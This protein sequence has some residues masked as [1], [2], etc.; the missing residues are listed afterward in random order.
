MSSF[1]ESAVVPAVRQAHWCKPEEQTPHWLADARL[2][3]RERAA[4]RVRP[5]KEERPCRG[6]K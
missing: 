1:V 4:A 2:E 5:G 3:R 6:S